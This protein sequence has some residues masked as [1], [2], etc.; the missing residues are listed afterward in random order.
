MKWGISLSVPAETPPV[1]VIKGSLYIG[2]R[3]QAH[4]W[5]LLQS[6]AATHVVNA[7]RE[8][9]EP[10]KDKIK[11]HQCGI[12]DTEKA[13]IL[14]AGAS[15]FRFIED[16]LTSN[17]S[18]C[19]LVHCASGVSRSVALVIHY[20]MRKQGSSCNEALLLIR[21]VHP[22]AQPNQGFLSQLE[23]LELKLAGRDGTMRSKS[24]V[25][26]AQPCER[27]GSWERAASCED[28]GWMTR[29]SRSTYAASAAPKGGW[30]SWTPSAVQCST[31][32][33]TAE[34]K[35]ASVTI[36]SPTATEK[37][38]IDDDSKSIASTTLASDATGLS[39]ASECDDSSNNSSPRACPAKPIT[40]L[41]TRVGA[42]PVLFWQGMNECGVGSLL[43]SR[44][45]VLECNQQKKHAE[46]GRLVCGE[47]QMPGGTSGGTS[48]AGSADMQA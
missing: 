24:C 42:T 20:L 12:P 33:N 34:G 41:A 23:A 16:A 17:D 14:G 37:T 45:V 25:G 15:S 4:N 11:Y 38:D 36:V 8:V 27:I 9:N 18:A 40:P 7:S 28:V 30:W 21:A 43:S 1:E 46:K 22:A 26:E 44:R 32:G 13:D 35:D 31:V 47:Q 39:E 2:N 48:T 3:A 29:S 10:F 6:L 5:E 19:V